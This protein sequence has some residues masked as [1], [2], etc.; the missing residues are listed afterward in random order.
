MEAHPEGACRA[1]TATPTAEPLVKL[2]V[3]H[4]V[5]HFMACDT[6]RG[7]AISEAFSEALLRLHDGFT[8][9]RTRY[10]NCVF[11]VP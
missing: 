9:K 5:K 8:Q 4:L 10:E 11:R 2:L 6:H 7:E 1:T 3:K